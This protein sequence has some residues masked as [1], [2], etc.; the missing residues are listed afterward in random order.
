[1]NDEMWSTKDIA[2]WLKLELST[3]EQHVVTRQGFPRSTK[4]L[5]GPIWKRGRVV[6]F[7]K[8]SGETQLY[9]H[10]NESGDLL[11]VG[12]SLSAAA[13]QASHKR[14]SPWFDQVRNITVEVF[15]TRDAALKG[16]LRAIRKEKPLFNRAGV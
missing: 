9:R 8:R 6:Q 16:E 3:V 15:K 12:V 14:A 13:R 5:D 10:F 11:Y 7:F 2:L 1:M 4:T